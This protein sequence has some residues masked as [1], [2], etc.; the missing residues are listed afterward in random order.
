V[1]ESDH[2]SLKSVER[3]KLTVGIV[4]EEDLQEVGALFE[5]GNVQLLLGLVL[6]GNCTK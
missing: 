1:L 3:L 6:C 4:I 5:G 2:D